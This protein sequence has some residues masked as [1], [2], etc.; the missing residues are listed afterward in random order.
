MIKASGVAGSHSES[1]ARGICTADA[2]DS[3]TAAGGQNASKTKCRRGARISTFRCRGGDRTKCRVRAT[4]HCRDAA[5]THG[6]TRD[7]RLPT[8]GRHTRQPPGSPVGLRRSDGFDR[9]WCAATATDRWGIAAT[10][11]AARQRVLVWSQ[12]QCV[13][14]RNMRLENCRACATPGQNSRRGHSRRSVPKSQRRRQLA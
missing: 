8:A 3:W 7:G 9:Q 10:A 2:H 6:D 14:V 12:R 13:A 1:V 4:Q 5:R 11:S